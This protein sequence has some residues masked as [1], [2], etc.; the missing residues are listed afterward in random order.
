MSLKLTDDDAA[1]MHALGEMASSGREEICLSLGGHIEGAAAKK[2]SV[3][4]RLKKLCENPD[5]MLVLAALYLEGV[6]WECREAVRRRLQPQGG[7][8]DALEAQTLLR[9]LCGKDATSARG[10]TACLH[11]QG[12]L[13][14]AMLVS[15]DDAHSPLDGR[16]RLS[17]WLSGLLYPGA[18]V[19]S[20]ERRID[21]DLRLSRPAQGFSSL[22][23]DDSLRNCLEAYKKLVMSHD[24]P[25]RA[26]LFWGKAGL[27][28]TMAAKAMAFECGLPAA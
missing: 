8:T 2:G 10:I 24:G 5:E 27:G 11:P 7:K 22:V 17:P 4:W 13:C 12:R 9:W 1:W 25:A 3:A 19:D 21:G 6:Q 20:G 28:K 23:L 15:R 18:H 14:S 26:A 16:I